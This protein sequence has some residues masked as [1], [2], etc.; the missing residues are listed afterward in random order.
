MPSGGSLPGWL[1]SMLVCASLKES[2][3]M[4]SMTPIR[5]LSGLRTSQAFCGRGRLGLI[6][7]VTA[8]TLRTILLDDREKRHDGVS[9]VMAVKRELTS[10]RM[11]GEGCQ[12]AEQLKK[13]SGLVMIVVRSLT[14]R[15]SENHLAQGPYF[16]RVL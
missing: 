11:F 8:L 5:K 9:N 14:H 4:R 2:P 7:L 10:S 15:R 12:L 1:L 3:V 13:F 6:Q 16:V